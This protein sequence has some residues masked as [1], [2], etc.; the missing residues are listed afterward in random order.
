MNLRIKKQDPH[1]MP[2]EQSKD[3]VVN[4]KKKRKAT[5]IYEG[6]TEE[7]FVKLLEKTPKLHHQ[8]AFLLAY[9]S[10]LRI[11]EVVK[12]KSE[13]ID[14]KGNKIFIRQGK[15]SKDRIVNIPK[16]M[17]DK[18]IKVLP[19]NISTR[20]LEMVFL[21]NSIKA[22]INR[23][24]ATYEAKGKQIPI[25]RLH[26]HSLRHGFATRALEKGVPVNM[27]QALLGHSNL[28]TTN[29]YTKANPTDAINSILEK[30]V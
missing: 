6:V 10:G 5:R 28:A 27:V 21:R 29:R 30:G 25:Y 12:L 4:I 15:G 19:I 8:T 23:V 14:V 17:K 20:A 16:Q 22:G 2:I 13:D 11:S 3:E 24:I 9:G 18:H 1:K 26:Y 7:E